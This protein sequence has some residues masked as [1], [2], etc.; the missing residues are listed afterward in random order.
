MKVYFIKD[1]KGKGKKG[2]IIDVSDGYAKN[3]LIPQ[4]LAVEATNEIVLEK[5]TKDESVLYHKEQD[6][7]KAK[8][9]AKFLDNKTV[10]ISAKAGANGKLFGTITAKEIAYYIEEQYGQKIDKR[11]IESPEIKSFGQFLI[12]L[13]VAS[14]VVSNMTVSVVEEN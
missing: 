12:K 13:K 2:E 6:L 7:L 14:G 8:E 3:F 1:V 11:K 4:Q 9:V 10:K 5:K